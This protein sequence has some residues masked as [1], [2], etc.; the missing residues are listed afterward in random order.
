MST[1]RFQFINNGELFMRPHSA[2]WAQSDGRFYPLIL[3]HQHTQDVDWKALSEKLYQYVDPDVAV[4]E[5]MQI[6]V[7]IDVWIMLSAK[8]IKVGSIHLSHY[9]GDVPNAGAMQALAFFL[10]SAAVWYARRR[11]EDILGYEHELVQTHVGHD[12]SRRR[13]IHIPIADLIH[14]YAAPGV[15]DAMYTALL[16]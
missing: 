7:D 5:A 10:A 12:P 14:Q 6:G 13:R 9:Y 11:G 16:P 1:R 3:G 8:W 4:E 2:G 15:E